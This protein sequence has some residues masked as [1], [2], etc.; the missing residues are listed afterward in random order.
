MWIE[1]VEPSTDASMSSGF[2]S[3]GKGI[4]RYHDCS[5]RI[6]AQRPLC[7]RACVLWRRP[8]TVSWRPCT[9]TWMSSERSPSTGRST[10]QP[11][12]VSSHLRRHQL[13]RGSTP[14]TANQLVEQSVD[15]I[16]HR[17]KCHGPTVT[18]VSC[19]WQRGIRRATR[20]EPVKHR[21]SLGL[22]EVRTPSVE[23]LPHAWHVQRNVL[24]V[25][26]EMLR[27]RT[28]LYANQWWGT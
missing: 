27:W 14:W 10:V 9:L 19:A 5:S 16:E 2:A 21:C 22:G 17:G 1:S 6:C 8:P 11:S 18:T 3:A 7:R 26:V 20:W 13:P 23:A 15:L 4:V 28:A 25:I 12:A 24:P